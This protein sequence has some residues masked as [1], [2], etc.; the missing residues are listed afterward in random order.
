MTW[1]MRTAARRKD[2]N[3]KKFEATNHM[4]TY[5]IIRQTWIL[6]QGRWFFGTPFSPFVGFPNKFTIPCPKTWS[7]NR[8]AYHSARNASLGLVTRPRSCL[9]HWQ[10]HF[11][12][13][14]EDNDN[15][16][17][18]AWLLP[19]M[20]GVGPLRETRREQDGCKQ[21]GTLIQVWPCEGG[22][23]AMSPGR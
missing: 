10:F 9:S 18:E 20:H 6:T 19:G 5:F 23:R 16:F 12:A 8:L 22:S 21:L 1:P 11:M 14:K 4:F 13:T 17:I 15:H 3:T 7:L 2:S